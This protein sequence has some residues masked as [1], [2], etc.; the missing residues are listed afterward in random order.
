MNEYN[1]LNLSSFE[2]ENF[3]R[4][5]LQEK[6]EL[7]FESFTSGQDGGVDLRASLNLDE[8][9]IV[10]AKRYTRFN[11][12]KST[13]N[14][15]IDKVKELNPVRYILITSVGLTP[16][17]KDVI[18]QLFQPYIHSTEDILGR[19]DLNNL[20]GLYPKIE[21]KYY[22]LW[23]SSTNILN[24]LINSTVYN[25]SKFEL[26]E[27]KESLKVYVQNESFNEAIGIL[28][29][30][31]YVIISGIPGIGKTTLSR[32]LVYRLLA[33]DFD[34]FVYVA[35]S[36]NDAYSYFEDGKKQVFF[37]DDFLGKNFLETG[38]KVNEDSKLIKFIDRIKNSKNKI[39]ILAT[40]EY[41]L[42]QAKNSFESLNTPSLDLVKCT[43]DLSKYTK[44]IRAE[45]LFNHLFFANIPL[46]HLRNL[47][48]TKSYTRLIDHKS[49]NPRIIETF[50]K[51]QFWENCEP[52]E[53]SKK[54]ISF[55][56][57]PESVWLHAFENTIS[58]GSQIT[59][60]VLSTLGTPVLLEDLKISINS[61]ITAN[62]EKYPLT[63]DSI[64]F[65]KI[66]KE[67]ESTFISTK[68]DSN[69]KIAVEFQNPSIQDFL[70][71]YIDGKYDL[72]ID[73][74]KS[75]SF[76]SQFFRIFT[77]D[78]VK[79]EYNKRI[80]LD[81]KILKEYVSKILIDFDLFKT[82]YIFRLNYSESNTF[83]WW[84]NEEFFYGFLN[85]IL[86]ELEN[87]SNEELKNFVV[88]KFN[89]NI[90][91]KRM[92]YSERRAYVDLIGK[93]GE[94]QIDYDGAKLISDFAE[95]VDTIDSL[96]DFSK[97]KDVFSTQ[98][99]EYTITDDFNQK[100]ESVIHNEIENTAIEKYKSLIEELKEIELDFDYMLDDEI[101]ELTQKHDA[102]EAKIDAKFDMSDYEYEAR[103]YEQEMEREEQYISD[104]F[105]GLMDK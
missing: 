40:R 30:N 13:L 38:L 73:L 58:K 86:I 39:F 104:L 60:L 49:Y 29:K 61:F 55:F 88:E 99:E 63:I 71:N 17:N 89:Q 11:D 82:S 9:I 21:E 4:D 24:K 1:F 83:T 68:M 48:E 85:Q 47:I 101:S 87:A 102:Y 97:F 26:D 7:F 14:T 41:I 67:L 54:L 56:D 44:T 27:I 34:D 8:N 75:F 31:N 36:I 64:E 78:Q 33:E 57:N 20:L 18:L 52:K 51:N 98:Y 19:D 66:I 25:Q 15:E 2:F 35:D 3:S 103:E 72:I 79:K 65:R 100:F 45:I 5:I 23:L 105:D 42:K 6:L 93:I 53:F 50:V 12:L 10:Q 69:R 59:L 37:F 16:D 90:Q 22:K 96:K 77:F 28:K 94:S 81:K 92:G 62:I 95:H 91:P 76:V 43:L 32:M 46:Q 70:I 80:I 74:I 84:K